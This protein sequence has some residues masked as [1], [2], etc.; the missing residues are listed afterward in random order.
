VNILG[1]I[2]GK[3]KSTF[4]LVMNVKKTIQVFKISYKALWDKE[5]R[6]THD[7]YQEIENISQKKIDFEH[8]DMFSQ[9]RNKIIDDLD[10]DWEQATEKAHKIFSRGLDELD[11]YERE[12]RGEY[13]VD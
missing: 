11:D 2:S 5:Y 9:V 1:F 4:N 7:I 8:R 10:Y 6:E 13:H 3:L 12:T